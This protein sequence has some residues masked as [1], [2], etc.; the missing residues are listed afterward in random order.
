MENFGEFDSIIV[1]TFEG[2]KKFYFKPTFLDMDFRTHD[3]YNNIT[4]I[5]DRVFNYILYSRTNDLVNFSSYEKVNLSEYPN[6]LCISMGFLGNFPGIVQPIKNIEKPEFLEIPEAVFL[7][8]GRVYVG[9]GLL[10][11]PEFMGNVPYLIGLT[12][13]LFRSNG[14]PEVIYN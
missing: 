6:R 13:A 14:N 3:I 2:D 9:E 11:T 10:K 12:A 4:K 8:D 7:N 1:G 5:S